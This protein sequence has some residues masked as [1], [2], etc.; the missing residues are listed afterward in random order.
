MSEPE[1]NYDSDYS[2]KYNTLDRRRVP[3]PPPPQQT[4]ESRQ[5]YERNY[6]TMPNPIKPGQQVYKNQPGRI[7]NYLTGHSSISEKET[8]QVS[9]GFK[10]NMKI[11]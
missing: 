11:F 8:K 7:E 5:Y 10:I 9:L 4:S 2:V 6:G 1:P 3:P